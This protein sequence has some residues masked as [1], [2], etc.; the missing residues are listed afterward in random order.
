[1]HGLGNDFVI[2]DGRADG[3]LPDPSFCRFV[4]DRHEGVGCDQLIAL[5]QP[6]SAE[7]DVFMHMANADGSLV[8]G[9]GNATRCVARLLF[10]ETGKSEA[11]IETVAGLLRVARDDDEKIAV[12]FGAP[13]LG[14]RDL[15]LA[16]AGDTLHLPLALGMLADPCGVSVG[17]PHAVFFVD[18][19]DAVP[20]DTLGPAL[21]T[22]ALFPD[23]CNIEIAHIVRPDSI[24][25]RVWE[26]GAGLT[27]AC[28]TGAMATLVAAVR[29]G[30][31]ARRA[32]VSM[33][34]GALDIAWR[35]TDGHVMMIG[36][37]TLVFRGTLA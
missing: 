37:A 26:R 19:V 35:E 33:P 3:F 17:N 2:F 29:R 15:P 30:L 16:T 11:V 32:T 21:E 5:G 27:R 18:D 23:R 28:G 9:C 6:V 14:W 13:R 24:R 25:M 20:L 31:S 7:A 12:D 22:H 8:R 10:D 36:T 1:M 34:G 4:A